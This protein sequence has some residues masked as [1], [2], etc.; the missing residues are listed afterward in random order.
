MD[1]I[2]IS[3]G[4]AIGKVLVY[5]EAELIIEKKQITNIKDEIKRLKM[6]IERAT[7][8]IDEL[9]KEMLSTVGKYEAAIFNAHKMILNDPKFIDSIKSRINEHKVNAEYAI[10]EISD[11]YISIFKNM[12]DEYLKAR[13]LDIEDISKRLVRI[14]LGVKNKDLRS[15]K[16]E[17]ILV[18]EK[19]TPSD[20][21]QMNKDM[22]M[23][24]VTERG[25]RT[26][27]TSIMIRAMEIPYV[28]GIK[29]IIKKVE[30]G[31]NIIVDGSKGL[32]ITNPSQEQIEEYR[33]K[34][35]E[36]VRI[37][38]EIKRIKGLRSISKDGVEVR[39]AANIG[40]PKDVEKVLENDGQGIGLY[41]SEFLYLNRDSVPSEEEQ[42]NAYRFV[43]EKMGGKPVVART[44]DVGGD[45]HVYCL[46]LPKESN[47]FLGYRA[48]RLCLD[49]EDIFK[50]Q[51]RAIL[52][53]SAYGNIKIAFPM[54]SSIEEIR[55]A[56]ALLE[57]VKEELRLK[58]IPFNENLKIGMMVET[59]AAAIH[60]NIFAEEV[61]FFSIGTNDLIQYTLA[62]DREN[63]A[64]SHLYSQ[65]DPAV[66]KLIK[67]IID[68]GHRA[69]IK[70][71]MCGEA[72]SDEK[73][74]PVFLA[75]GL[76]EFSMNPSSLLKSKWIIKNTCKKEIEPMI[77]T[78][79]SLP[80][81]KEVEEFIDE[82]ILKKEEM[83]P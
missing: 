13:A 67:M 20:I 56:K 42:F 26:S 25:G 5:K 63:E 55:R 39:L 41:R 62:V 76:D 44:L 19:L 4:I 32:V 79:L 64:I 9:Y 74:I 54:V 49:M 48:I 7:K 72:A 16:E 27:H 78:I 68:N 57:E 83:N 70:V 24:I 61:D 82:N 28:T 75:M 14:L 69:G 2:G 58:R 34:K 18:A 11:Y 77:E 23:A 10:R 30:D 40:N 66:L 59:P 38:D 81:A 71:A 37:K 36:F 50:I 52:K 47:P 1:G 45:K 22:V 15:I 80:T 73:L 51:L 21:A 65:Y 3:A 53:A 6:S 46:N 35:Y 8:E 31:E 12:E 33:A 17:C 43:A 60:S 29:D